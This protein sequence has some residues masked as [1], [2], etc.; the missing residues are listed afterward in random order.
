MK[1]HTIPTVNELRTTQ[2]GTESLR[3]EYLRTHHNIPPAEAIEQAK[4]LYPDP[5][6]VLVHNCIRLPQRVSQHAGKYVVF[7]PRTK[8]YEILT[9]GE[10]SSNNFMVRDAVSVAKLFTD[11]EETTEPIPQLKLMQW[12]VSLS[13]APLF[14]LA[15]PEDQRP[16]AS[17]AIIVHMT[18]TFAPRN[19]RDAFMPVPY[20][21]F[22]S[23]SPEQLDTLTIEHVQTILTEYE[24]DREAAR[25]NRDQQVKMMLAD[26]SKRGAVE[27][28]HKATKITFPT[29]NNT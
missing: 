24:R 2:L 7:N 19:N 18:S 21:L 16:R 27:A 4:V 9:T 13:E 14:E 25:E 20:R 10:Y 29:E 23:F 28:S 11:D 22:A 5:P 12:I 1:S 8:R 15:C 6:K 3:Y 26:D 17:V